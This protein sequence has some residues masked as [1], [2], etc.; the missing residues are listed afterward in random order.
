MVHFNQ[1]CQ[2]VKNDIILHKPGR[3]KQTSGQIHIATSGTT[4]PVGVI[5]F[6]VDTTYS[7]SEGLDIDL[8]DPIG[9]FS[10]KIFGDD[11]G[12][13]GL[14]GSGALPGVEV[15][16]EFQADRITHQFSGACDA[17]FQIQGKRVPPF[18]Y[19]EGFSMLKLLS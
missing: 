7:L 16:V 9:N 8:C 2:F 1:M 17:I 3:K 12:K 10:L 13:Q 11:S 15:F 18:P 5:V 14:C 4:A 6:K 19:Q